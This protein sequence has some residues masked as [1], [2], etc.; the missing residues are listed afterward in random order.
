MQ[1]GPRIKPVINQI[2]VHPFNTQLHI[3]EVTERH[4]IAVQAYASMVRGMRMKHPKVV[5][6]AQKNQCTPAQLLLKYVSFSALPDEAKQTELTN[7]SD[8]ACSRA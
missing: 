1:S 8:G 3:R 7:V 5:A 2:E 4:G 6:L